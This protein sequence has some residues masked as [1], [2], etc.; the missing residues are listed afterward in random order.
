MSILNY[1]SYGLTDGVEAL[2]VVDGHEEQLR[3]GHAVPYMPE[4]IELS[5]AI[6]LTIANK[7]LQEMGWTDTN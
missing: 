2:L 3:F 1:G 6:G 7:M 5:N 4:D